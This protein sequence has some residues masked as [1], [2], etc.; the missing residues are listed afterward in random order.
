MNDNNK[1]NIFTQTTKSAVPM[2]M[3]ISTHM[4]VLSTVKNAIPQDKSVY[5]H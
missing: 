2:M 1:I 4:T 5:L 3:N